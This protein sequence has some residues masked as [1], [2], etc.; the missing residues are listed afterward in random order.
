MYRRLLGCM[1][2]VGLLCFSSAL[3]MADELT[4]AEEEARL[5]TGMEVEV[6]SL[7][8]R[9]N[10]GAHI[11]DGDVATR[12]RRWIS[13]AA[14]TE[15]WLMLMLPDA[16]AVDTVVLYSGMEAKDDDPYIADT[17]VIEAMQGSDWVQVAR[18]EGNLSYRCVAAFPAFSS[19]AWR[20]RFIKG[21]NWTA[22]VDHRARVFEVRLLQAK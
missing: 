5:V 14:E 16:V 6:S 20:I 19:N 9:L 7:H 18:V 13:Q 15:P 2:I 12:D 1:L 17:F 22:E 10:V 4:L 8:H 11:I 3:A 21:N